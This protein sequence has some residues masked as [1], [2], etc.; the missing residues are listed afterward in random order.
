MT[1]TECSLL[2]GVL[3]RRSLGAA[4]SGAGMTR[5]VAARLIHRLEMKNRTRLIGDDTGAR[6]LTPRGRILLRASLD[7]HESLIDP[8]RAAEPAEHTA[9][10]ASSLEGPLDVTPLARLEPPLVVDVTEAD[11]ASAVE[12]FDGGYADA[13]ALWDLPGVACPARDAA[14]VPLFDEDLWVVGRDVPTSIDRLDDLADILV[15]VTTACQ[16]QVLESVLGHGAGHPGVRVVESRQ[17]HRVLVLSG[18]ASGLV[19]AS[20][21]AAFDG[22]G[23]VRSRPRG[24]TRTAVLFSDPRGRTHA[25]LADV[26]AVFRDRG[27]RMS[28]IPPAQARPRVPVHGPTP[29][30]DLQDIKTLQAIGRHG[31]LNRAAAELCLTQPALTRR[32]RKLEDRVGIHL[33]VRTAT[34]SS[35]TPD[36]ATMVDRVDTAIARFQASVAGPPPA[37][38]LAP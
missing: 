8:L 13:V 22:F 14:A 17:A 36:A 26:Q 11:P 37:L 18:R 10:I 25:R 23:M 32:L 7:L 31:S 24:L 28:P 30:L 33:V 15:W 27:R 3:R 16:A 5:A 6:G 1:V 20:Q 35:L 34:G 19:P 12:L 21:L 9:R 4:A 29:A 2:T 38:A